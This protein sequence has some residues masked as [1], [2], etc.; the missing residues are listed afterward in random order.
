MQ[1]TSARDEMEIAPGFK[2]AAWKGLVLDVSKPDAA[3]WQFA[4]QVFEARVAGRF[5]NPV[6]ELIKLE[7][8]RSRKT[9][10]FA[11]LSL[12]FIV[13]EALQGIRCGLANHKGQSERL[14]TSFLLQWPTFLRHVPQGA[15]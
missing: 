7:K 2:V 14:L 11:I 8:T 15:D 6:D 13:A 1:P 3:D 9:F 12:D 4:L 5:L 10:G